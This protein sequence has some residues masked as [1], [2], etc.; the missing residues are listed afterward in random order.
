MCA[1]SS[2]GHRLNPAIQMGLDPIDEAEVSR[3]NNRENNT[4]YRGIDNSAFSTL[5]KMKDR[6]DIPRECGHRGGDGNCAH[7]Q[8]QCFND[9]PDKVE[10][11]RHKQP[12]EKCR[13][14]HGDRNE[15]ND[16]EKNVLLKDQGGN[17]GGGGVGEAPKCSAAGTWVVSVAAKPR[18]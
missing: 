7:P 11:I 2:I 14:S 4:P 5:R 18:P 16:D 1:S 17:C 3:N 13:V 15:G 12:R 8:P 10:G 6:I 9:V